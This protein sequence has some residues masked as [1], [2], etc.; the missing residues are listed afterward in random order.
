[1]KNGSG[2]TPPILRV[3]GMS[4]YYGI[5]N[6][7]YIYIWRA[8]EVSETVQIR[9]DAVSVTLSLHENDGKGLPG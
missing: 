1:M 8:S 9:A 2:L 6:S 7:I 5:R 3:S 4:Y